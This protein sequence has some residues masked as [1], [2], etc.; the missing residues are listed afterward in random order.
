MVE[1]S[2]MWNVLVCAL[3]CNSACECVWGFVRS[4]S[5]W[6]IVSARMCYLWVF[7]RGDWLFGGASLAA[8]D[9]CWCVFICVCVCVC[10]RVCVCVCACVRVCVC[11]YV[12]NICI[13][14]CVYMYVCVYVWVLLPACE[15]MCWVHNFCSAVHR[16]HLTTSR[17][18]DGPCSRLCACRLAHLTTSQRSSRPSILPYLCSSY[19]H[20]PSSDR[21]L[22][23][24]P[25][26][27]SN[28]QPAVE[29]TPFVDR[30]WWFWLR[31]MLEKRDFCTAEFEMGVF[32]IRNVQIWSISRFWL[33]K[34]TK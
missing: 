31:W 20:Q 21:R 29:Q 8:C 19:D 4:W 2:V 27:S 24:R 6:L 10:V 12:S 17:T 7:M 26:Q 32:C 22:C 13:M 5:V 14:L 1:V 34:Q 11:V 3:V 30:V 18:A 15:F 9:C 16:A 33:L 23:C 25:C 28:H